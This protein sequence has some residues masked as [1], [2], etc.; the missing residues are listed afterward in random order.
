MKYCPLLVSLSQV[1]NSSVLS[2][3]V[4]IPTFWEEMTLSMVKNKPSLGKIMN[5]RLLELQFCRCGR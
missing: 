1:T 3:L 2:L 5:F 4:D